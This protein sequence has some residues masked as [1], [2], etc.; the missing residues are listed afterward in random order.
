MYVVRSLGHVFARAL[1]TTNVGGGFHRHAATGAT[2]TQRIV[3]TAD[4]IRTPAYPAWRAPQRSWRLGGA[5][6]PASKRIQIRWNV[7]P[8]GT[9]PT[10]LRYDQLRL[11]VF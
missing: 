3:S 9:R 11:P 2:G 10:G 5:E 7:F 4:P 8:D 1:T 6:Y